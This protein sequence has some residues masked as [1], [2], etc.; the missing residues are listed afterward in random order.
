MKYNNHV[1]FKPVMKYIIPS[2]NGNSYK[3]ISVLQ[4]N[5]FYEIL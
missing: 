4:L 5:I 2:F 3:A 1:T